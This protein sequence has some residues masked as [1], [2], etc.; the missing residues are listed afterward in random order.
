MKLCFTRMHS[1]SI[2]TARS[3]PWGVSLAETPGTETHLDRDPPGQRYP[4][5]E[6]ND[7]QVLKHYLPATSFADGKNLN[8]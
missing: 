5:C 4:L 1:S 7:R 8:C 2:R 6:Q 3:L